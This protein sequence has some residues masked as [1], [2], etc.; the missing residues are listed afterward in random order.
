MT[1]TWNGGVKDS[2]IYTAAYSYTTKAK[3]STSNVKSVTST[4][5]DTILVNRDVHYCILHNAILAAIFGFG[6]V[7]RK[8]VNRL[9]ENIP[10][11]CAFCLCTTKKQWRALVLA[12]L[13]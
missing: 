9:T 8:P 10:S 2:R 11:C 3:L 12:K 1:Y 6:S 7:N 13:K 4:F 5:Y